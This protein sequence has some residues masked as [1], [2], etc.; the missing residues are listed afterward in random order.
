[1]AEI[2]IAIAFLIAATLIGR[3]LTPTEDELTASA[4]GW[5]QLLAIS[6]AFDELVIEAQRMGDGFEKLS[7]TFAQLRR[8]HPE[9]FDPQTGYLIE[10]GQHRRD[11]SCVPTLS[12]RTLDLREA[13]RS[14]M[15]T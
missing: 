14:G 13:L 4:S 15:A 2:L 1:M 7:D 6:N 8:D 10:Q 3:W 12:R 9:W 5:V 11:R